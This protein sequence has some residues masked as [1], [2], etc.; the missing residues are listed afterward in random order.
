[1]KLYVLFLCVLAWLCPVKLIAQSASFT[2][3]GK[4]VV[5]KTFN[6]SFEQLLKATD[7]PGASLAIIDHNKIAFTGYYG[8]KTLKGQEKVDAET[9]F[10]ACSLSKSYLVYAAFRLVEEGKLDL[11]K[12]VYQYME[13]GAALDHDVRYKLITPRMILSHCSG[14]ENWKED[15]NRDTLEILTD[16]GKSFVYSGTGYNYLA[17]AIAT[18][19]GKPYETYVNELVLQPLHLQHSYLRF[20]KDGPF[21]YATGHN[22]FG[23]EIPKWKNEEA[24][25]SSANNVTAEDYARLI[26]ATFDGQHLS[27]K[28]EQ[29][30]LTPLIS[31]SG[32]QKPYYYGPGFEIFYAEGDTIISHGGNNAGFKGQLFYSLKHKCGFVLLTNGDRG[33]L[34]VSAL[35]KMTAGLPVEAYYQQISL[36][37]YPDASVGLFHTY[38][39]SGLDAMQDSIKVMEKNKKL[40]EGTLNALGSVFMDSDTALSRKLLQNNLV[41]YPGS[42]LGYY[43]LGNLYKNRYA[44]DIA[45][46]YYVKAKAL[47]FDLWET[48]L[49]RELEFCRLKIADARRRTALLAEVNAAGQLTLQAEAYNQMQGIEVRVTKDSGG[50]QA[51]GFIDTGDWMNYKVRVPDAGRYQLQLRVSSEPGNGRAELRSGATVIAAFDITSTKSWESFTTLTAYADLP[52]GLQT[53]QLYAAKGGFDVN[54]IQFTRIKNI[55]SKK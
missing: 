45:Y 51:L 9:V 48:E 36:E 11:D 50:G 8:V 30:L 44:Y 25:P 49:T 17:E 52:A 53:F 10:E 41:L 16:P 27:K 20:T 33:K 19:I 37:E 4:K 32:N 15:N 31:T 2:V 18:I 29:A 7:I 12:P 13:P 5:I 22:I 21:N 26:I 34:A 47:H 42:S 6:S 39:T 28:T 3:N 38:L 35:N 43:L 40:T 24:V 23:K 46:G 55:S 14:I 1:M 54:W